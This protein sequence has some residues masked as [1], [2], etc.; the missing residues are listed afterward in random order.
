MSSISKQMN[1][2]TDVIRFLNIAKENNGIVK[3][4]P[5]TKFA[6]QEGQYKELSNYFKYVIECGGYLFP[7]EY[8]SKSSKL[9]PKKKEFLKEIITSNNKDSL[10]LN[11]YPMFGLPEEK[12]NIASLE[13]II[14]FFELVASY[15]KQYFSNSVFKFLYEE[16]PV[17]AEAHFMLKEGDEGSKISDKIT[18]EF[19]HLINNSE[20]L[21][22]WSEFLG[23]HLKN[24]GRWSSFPILDKSVLSS[25]EFVKLTENYFGN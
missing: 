14:S 25:R 2:A 3:N 18:K 15:H 17:R 11:V 23:S 9:T 24:I 6:N 19:N 1:L 12:H 21:T 16:N 20:T 13:E 22:I 7:A 4:F 5:I 8:F 10:D